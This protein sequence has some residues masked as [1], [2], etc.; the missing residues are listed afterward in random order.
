[1]DNTKETGIDLIDTNNNVT[2]DDENIVIKRTQE[3]T[4]DFLRSIDREKA[5]TASE[6]ARMGEMVHAASIPTVV[7]EQWLAE[8]FNIFSPDVK[9]PDI[10]KRLRQYDMERLIATQKRLY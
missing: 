8:G 4:D 1:M 3:V 6:F 10:M 9:L 5:E 2:I 7:V